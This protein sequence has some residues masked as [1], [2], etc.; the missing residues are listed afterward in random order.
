MIR[1]FI[2]E[3]KSWY[4]LYF[5][6]LFLNFL[7]FYLVH[8]PLDYF[9]TAG[10]VS[11]GFLLLYTVPSYL[12]FK[13]KIEIL[14]DFIY[15]NELNDLQSPSELAYLNVIQKI[16]SQSDF[17]QQELIKQKENLNQM[18]KMWVHQMKIPLSVLSLMEQTKAYDKVEGK[19][20]LFKMENYLKQLLTYLK[21]SDYNDD[22]I[23]EQVQVADL[24]K[25]IIKS[26]AYVCISKD[27]SISV[28][29]RCKLKTDRKWLSFALEQIID[30]AIKYSKHGGNI[31]I[32]LR[33]DSIEISDTGIGIL[34][35]DINRI[36][37]DGFTGFNGH[38]HQKASGLGLYMTKKVLNNLEL[39][40]SI[41]SEVEQ[42]TQVKITRL[43][44]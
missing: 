24:I 17:S 7:V 3:Y 44:R 39:E 35:S 9:I 8:L 41:T 30:N 26:Y 28:S 27:I 22:Y 19:I 23:F 42:G 21:F 11:L 2:K 10:W 40:I 29:G 12:K 16:L 34:D 15:V 38:E 36:F 5:L 1:L 14:Q 6:L 20:Q 32:E 18:I 37:D 13:R 31:K 4:I 33:D 43:K 25:Q